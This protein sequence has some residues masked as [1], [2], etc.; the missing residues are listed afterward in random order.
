MAAK[1]MKE[2]EALINKKI[3]QAL[4]TE[5]SKTARNSLK[6]HIVDDVYEAYT[7][8][9]YDRTGG[10][11][12]DRNIDTH[13]EN[14]NTLSVRSTREEDGRDI[15]SIIEYGKGYSYD[16]LDERIGARPFHEEVAKEL[17]N[18]LAKDALIKGLKKQGIEVK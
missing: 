12:Q 10:L 6:E 9:T 2:L 11:L 15:A 16:G 18:G 7:P 8:Q 3:R 5:V 13:M 4:E 1:N 14:D 17:A